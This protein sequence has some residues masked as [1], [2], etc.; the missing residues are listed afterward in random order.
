MNSNSSNLIKE[1]KETL[2]YIGLGQ[3]RFGEMYAIEKADVDLDQ[4]VIEREGERIKKQLQRSTTKSSDLESYLEFIRTT[5]EYQKA[6]VPLRG[7][8]YR[9]PNSTIIDYET[10]GIDDIKLENRSVRET[11]ASYA[12]AVG[13]AWNFQVI[14][15]ETNWLGRRFLVLWDGD[16]GMNGG[17]GSW[18]TA[19][20]EVQESRFGQFYVDKSDLHFN[21][22]MRCVARAIN[23]HKGVLS[24]VGYKY[25]KDD[26]NNH[27]SLVYKVNMKKNKSGEWHIASEQF[28][29]FKAEFELK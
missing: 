9:R 18:G 12:Y 3:K 28:L 24:L 1:I 22:G 2:T 25:G 26:P 6:V 17:S 21:T 10:I 29:G 13:F 7:I 27:P 14:Y 20:V 8:P 4:D 5:P 16:I 23:F 11:A 15:L 19:M